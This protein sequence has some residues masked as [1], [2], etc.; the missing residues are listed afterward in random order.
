[1][2]KDRV[3]VLV[4]SLVSPLLVG[5]YKKNRLI[6]SYKSDKKTSDILPDVF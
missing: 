1:M 6:Q 4:I 5:V 2:I 3:E